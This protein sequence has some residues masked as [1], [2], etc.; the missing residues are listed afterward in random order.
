MAAARF[1]I[2]LVSDRNPNRI[3]AS[4]QNLLIEPAL[5][6]MQIQRFEDDDEHRLVRA[7]TIRFERSGLGYVASF[8]E[9]N[10]AVSG[11]T[12]QDARQALEAEILDA[13]DDW[14]ADESTLGPGP[15]QQ[16]AVLRQYVERC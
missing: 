8:P 1:N 11:I 10:F 6:E 9:A 13:F 14:T 16:L 15:R 5:T 12:K 2:A 4:A 3:G 7:I